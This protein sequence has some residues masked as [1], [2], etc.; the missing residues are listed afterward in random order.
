M[1][2]FVGLGKKWNILRNR[3][4]SLEYDVDRLFI[5][6]LLFTILL[7]LFP[8]ILLYYTVFAA[9]Q[10]FVLTVKA[11]IFAVV[12]GF[13]YFPFWDVILYVI[14]SSLLPGTV[15]VIYSQIINEKSFMGNNRL[16]FFS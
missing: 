9:L 5:G 2:C 11:V 14:N 10:L 8:T 13:N 7:F 16:K 6:T 3:V 12:S 15:C 4:D 1:I